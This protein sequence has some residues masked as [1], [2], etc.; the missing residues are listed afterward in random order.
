MTV[1]KASTSPFAD[2]PPLYELA[3]I[4]WCRDYNTA[5]RLSEVARMHFRGNPIILT[6]SVDDVIEFI[7][8]HAQSLGIRITPHTDMLRDA[9]E[10]IAKITQGLAL[11]QSQGQLSAF[12]DAYRGWRLR[13]YAR[14]RKVPGYETQLAELR[15][16]IAVQ[17]NGDLR[18]AMAEKFPWLSDPADTRRRAAG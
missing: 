2:L 7:V 16:L 15:V 14:G 5:H 6:G 12:N 9:R 3:W 10:I 11:L 18:A 17:N 13:E 4:G 1:V 8:T